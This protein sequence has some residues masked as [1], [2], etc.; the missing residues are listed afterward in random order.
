MLRVLNIR[1]AHS[2][3]SIRTSSI[4]QNHVAYSENDRIIGK[5]NKRRC[6]DFKESWFLGRLF[7]RGMSLSL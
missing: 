4:R 1:T 3:L 2:H 7:G 5:G 6:M